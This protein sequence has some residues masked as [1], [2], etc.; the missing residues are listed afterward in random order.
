MAHEVP[1]VFVPKWV[2]DRMAQTQDNP[3]LAVKTGIEIAIKVMKDTWN[4]C[5]GYAISAPL[6]R[7]DVVLEVLKGIS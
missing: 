3:E 4:E 7:V 5:E 1:G 2:L 6:G